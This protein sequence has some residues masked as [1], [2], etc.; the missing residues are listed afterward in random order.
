MACEGDL[1]QEQ[2]VKTND[3][4]SNLKS[5]MSQSRICDV[6]NQQKLI[7]TFNVKSKLQ[8]KP[9]ETNGNFNCSYFW[10]LPDEVVLS[11]LQLMTELKNS[12]STDKSLIKRL[13]YGSGEVSVLLIKSSRK[14]SNFVPTSLDVL[15][16]Q[17]YHSLGFHNVYTKGFEVYISVRFADTLA[18]DNEHAKTVYQLLNH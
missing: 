7:E 12:G 2:G 15:Q 5:Y 17:E 11:R 6:I 18:E 10:N 16:F 9:H 8:I 13:R 4:K 14:T 1:T 3:K